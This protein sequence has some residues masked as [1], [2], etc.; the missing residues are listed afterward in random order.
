MGPH[1]ALVAVGVD[2]AL[3]DLVLEARG[4]RRRHGDGGPVERSWRGALDRNHGR[5]LAARRFE[6]TRLGQPTGGGVDVPGLEVGVPQEGEE[7]LK[8]NDCGGV[9][10][11]V[12]VAAEGLKGH[13][14]FPVILAAA[15]ERAGGEEPDGAVGA[16]ILAVARLGVAIIP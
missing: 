7:L 2:V 11:D 8:V 6:G 16:I 9:R 4:Q 1:V 12:D 14:D 15:E 5:D 10:R 13:G 3:T